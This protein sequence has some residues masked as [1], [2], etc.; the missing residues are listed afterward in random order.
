MIYYNLVI[1]IYFLTASMI[2][3]EKK[4][5]LSQVDLETII[6][7]CERWEDTHI[8]DYYLDTDE[9]ILLKHH[10]YLRLR[11]GK[12]E[13]KIYDDIKDELFR[14]IEIEDEDE[15]NKELGKFQISIDDTT[16]KV[17]VDTQRTRF[18]YEFEGYTFHIEVNIYQYDKRY[19]VELLLEDDSHI[20][21]NALIEKLREHL[22]LSA[23][24]GL[25]VCKV[26]TCALHQ[27]IAAYEAITWESIA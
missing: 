22:W 15:I 24:G 7:T 20:D 6:Q 10:Y 5:E 11:N 23:P 1:A 16:G 26:S 4:Y 27:D 17:F 13:L 21:G 3:I 8:K 12:Y 19:E 14:A 25:Q 18:Q 9:Y 2:E